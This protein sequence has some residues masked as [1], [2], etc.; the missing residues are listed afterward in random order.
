MACCCDV[1]YTGG[2]TGMPIGAGTLPRVVKA[3]VV[4]ADV[5]ATNDEEPSGRPGYVSN[6][7]SAVKAAYGTPVLGAVDAVGD[8]IDGAL[9]PPFIFV[10]ASPCIAAA[11]FAAVFAARS[12]LTAP[13]VLATILLSPAL[14]LSGD[15]SSPSSS[16]ISSVSA[17]TTASQP[18]PDRMSRC[19]HNHG[20]LG[21]SSA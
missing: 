14:S 16:I 9:G 3:G 19:S 13:G 1:V 6:G 10:T 5:D 2:L 12:C 7:G 4:F 8:K 18:R 17:F 21:S 15:S 20:L 11:T